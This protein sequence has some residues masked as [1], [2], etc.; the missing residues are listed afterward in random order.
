[1]EKIWDQFEKNGEK[2]KNIIDRNN[3][4]KEFNFNNLRLLQDAKKSN[5]RRNDLWAIRWYA[6]TFIKTCILY[7]QKNFC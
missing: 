1:M 5:Q 6:S 3:L 7:I 2:L 4:K